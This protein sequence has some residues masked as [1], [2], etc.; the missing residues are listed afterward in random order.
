[1]VTVGSGAIRSLV[2]WSDSPYGPNEFLSP[3]PV[4][5]DVGRC[6]GCTIGLRCFCLLMFVKRSTS[7]GGIGVSGQQSCNSQILV[8]LMSLCSL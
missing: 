7:I 8:F 5:A 6:A 2:I 3:H 4:P 1:M